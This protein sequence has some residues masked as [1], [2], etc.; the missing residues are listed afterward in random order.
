MKKRDV[1]QVVETNIEAM[2]TMLGL[3]RWE[4]NFEYKPISG[5]NKRCN[6]QCTTD[7]TWVNR[8]LITLVPGKLD[9][10]EE[11]LSVLLHEL[12]HCITSSYHLGMVATAEL[13]SKKEYQALLV[14]H[15]RADEEV[16][17]WIC[18]IINSLRPF[19]DK[20]K[21][22]FC[23][24]K[25]SPDNQLALFRVCNSCGQGMINKLDKLETNS[26]KKENQDQKKG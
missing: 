7:V 2:K 10:E 17:E 8:A 5:K 6:G 12:I 9:D 15:Y 21:C 18:K 4:I 19:P 3:D 16:T 11:V 23:N 14:L 22:S 24:I 26:S 25:H 20:E 13:T 1:Q